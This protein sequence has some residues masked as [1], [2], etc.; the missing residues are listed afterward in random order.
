VEGSL[1]GAALSIGT[2]FLLTR[3]LPDIK[4]DYTWFLGVLVPFFALAG[5]LY[6]S[7]LKRAA[8]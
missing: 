6:E 2:A 3:I 4:A 7:S 8:G 5:D 1:G